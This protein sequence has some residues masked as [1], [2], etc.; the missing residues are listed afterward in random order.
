V[1]LVEHLCH[2]P[3][4]DLRPYIH[5]P[6]D[7]EYY[8]TFQRKIRQRGTLKYL[9]FCSFWGP[10]FYFIISLFLFTLFVFVF[11][12]L[13]FLHLLYYFYFYFILFFRLF[14]F[15]LLLRIGTKIKCL[16]SKKISSQVSTLTFLFQ[17][18][19]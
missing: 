1:Y 17:N 12:I 19:P 6:S 10:Y 11:F 3:I 4:F 18:S 7:L 15:Y 5:T 16:R 13:F 8:L 9:I 2:T 14:S